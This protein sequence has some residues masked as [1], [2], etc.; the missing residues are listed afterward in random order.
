MQTQNQKYIKWAPKKESYIQK[1][2]KKGK[3]E[4]FVPKDMKKKFEKLEDN[5]ETKKQ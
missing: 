2:F 3:E 5:E 4:V 1:V